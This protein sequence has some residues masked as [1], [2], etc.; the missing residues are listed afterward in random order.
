MTS[1]QLELVDDKKV[2]LL[3]VVGHTEI[4]KPVPI[5]L[6]R[7]LFYAFNLVSHVMWL[8]RIFYGP[9]IKFLW[10]NGDDKTISNI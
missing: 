2:S 3:L 4:S 6:V 10:H 8:W 1:T 5:P 7:H 9:H